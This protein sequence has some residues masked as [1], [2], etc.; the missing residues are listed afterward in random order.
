MKAPNTT[1]IALFVIPPFPMKA[2]PMRREAR[3]MVTIPDPMVTFTD[4][5]LCAN[6]HPESA[7]KDEEIQR[8]IIVVK[9]GLI[10]ED[11]TMSGLS[12]VALKESPNLVLR[13]NER[14]TTT[15]ATK[16][17]AVINL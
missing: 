16:I 10:D 9:A 5:W 11:F 13:K 14:K 8:P 6:K 2:L 7:V 1:P 3:A 15:N 17:R 12:P 4:F